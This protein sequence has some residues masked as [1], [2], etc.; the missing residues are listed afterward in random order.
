MTHCISCSKEQNS[1]NENEPAEN[2]GVRISRKFREVKFGEESDFVDN[3]KQE[4]GPNNI[5][6]KPANSDD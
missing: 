5:T 1:S 2:E 4:S 6:H 3:L